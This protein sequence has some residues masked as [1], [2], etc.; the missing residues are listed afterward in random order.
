MATIQEIIDRVDE[1]VP[2]AFSQQVKLGW[3]A[4]LDGRIGLNVFLMSIAEVQCLRYAF[5]E[6]LKSEP[7]VSFPHDSIYDLWLESMIH[8]KNGEADRYQNTMQMYNAAY[9][10]FV[11]WFAQ[12]Y[13]PARGYARRFD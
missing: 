3:I 13:E 10:D 5:P 4:E 12:T 9:N 7:L 2:N 11:R 6:D 8:Y 1:N